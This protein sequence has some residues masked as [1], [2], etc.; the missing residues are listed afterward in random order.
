MDWLERTKAWLNPEK[1][2]VLE[3]LFQHQIHHLPIL[4]LLGK[5]G[6]GK[7]SLIHAL[8]GDEHVVIGN[9][10]QPCTKTA[11]AYDFPKDKPLLRFLDT[12]GLAE[13]DYDASED[14]AACENRSHA[15]VV[16]MKVDDPEQSAV[17]NALQQVRVAK[18]IRYIIVVHTG[19]LLVDEAMRQQAIAYNQQ[20]VETVVGRA[21]THV[22]VDFIGEHNQAVGLQA[23]RQVLAEI[24]PI[25]AQLQQADDSQDQE[26][27]G[28]A[29]VR[30]EVLWYAGAAAAS[31]ALPVAGAVAVSAIQ[32][33]LFHSLASHYGLTWDR[34]LFS[35]L[36]AA[37]GA[38]FGMQYATRFGIRQL[39]KLIPVYGQTVGTATSASMSFVATY[40]LGRV[41]AKYFYHR[42]HGEQVS[43]ETL[44]ALYEQVF[45]EM[46]GMKDHENKPII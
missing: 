46:L 39:I 36:L 21:L 1:N 41:A 3:K 24:L 32:G 15:L 45:S 11:Q 30:H 4:W 26:A 13:A 12:R 22:V 19:M 29:E 5:T 28:F 44:Q 35:E 25:L 18:R 31:D 14:I 42:Y 37:L 17:L 6:A 34:R 23:L 16:V 8:T 20:Q 7:S 38:G 27:M 33:K 43:R 9:G 40:A 2:P 10:F